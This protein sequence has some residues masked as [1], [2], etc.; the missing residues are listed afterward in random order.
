MHKQEG[1]S[2][3]LE[4]VSNGEERHA[5]K[6]RS[7]QRKLEEF[8]CYDE[9]L[10]DSDVTYPSTVDAGA[11]KSCPAQRLA[12]Q[13]APSAMFRAEDS[14]QQP[15]ELDNSHVRTC[16]GDEVDIS[17]ALT[18]PQ[19][20]TVNAE[21]PKLSSP[22]NSVSTH[23]GHGPAGFHIPDALLYDTS[24]QQ[25][26]LMRWTYGLYRGPNG[27]RVKVHYC[28]T[29]T[30]TERIARLFLD[31]EVL[32]FDIEWK[33]NCSAWQG[34]KK[35][36]ALI[37]IA[38]ETRIALFHIA[39]FWGEDS[40]EN[41]V[42]PTFKELMESQHITKVGVAIKSDC[43]RLRRFMGIDSRGLFELSHLY[44]LVKY[45]ATDASSVDKKL[46]KLA[47]QVEE[48]LG[49]PL[50]KGADV[51]SSD[52]SEGELDYEQVQYAASD[53]YAGLQLYYTLEAKR[54]SLTPVPPRPYHAEMNL[55]IRL[56]SGQ[57]IYTDDE[58]SSAGVDND[59]SPTAALEDLACNLLSLNIGADPTIPSS[60]PHEQ[61]P[62]NPEHP[63][64][65]QPTPPATPNPNPAYATAQKWTT[66]YRASRSAQ[67]DR[68]PTAPPTTLRAYALWHEEGFSVPE[69]A[70]ALRAP[71][72]QDAT[73]ASYV[74]EAISKEGLPYE[75]ARL[76][77]S[78]VGYLHE[79][80]RARFGA[81]LRRVG[82]GV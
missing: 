73:V 7:P 27:E 21:K 79:A 4:G 26:D 23:Q 50:W 40:V 13:Y 35:N 54:K 19:H 77:E 59:L 81:W 72:L 17:S 25:R 37:Q 78:V 34:I 46:V 33:A 39:R 62:L 66:A 41:L 8:T 10:Q 5:E 61:R 22:E 65:P 69:T 82:V 58:Q 16:I 52:W 63:P 36:V 48:H 9:D 6:T 80:A 53:S 57:A 64:S 49:L 71:P 44:K 24:D 74:I 31:E 60:K 76:E 67:D 2:E 28:K 20:H 12:S 42:A 55:P 18:G 15:R 70:A 43:T 32:G 75:K 38:C 51:R 11:V 56:F 45:S 14:H 30:D 68:K 47:T 29:R 3:L 1:F